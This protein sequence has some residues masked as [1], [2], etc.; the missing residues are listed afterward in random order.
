MDVRNKRREGVVVLREE[1]RRMEGTAVGVERYVRVFWGRGV[2]KWWGLQQHP[3]N[4]STRHLSP[5]L[6]GCASYD[7]RS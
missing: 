3:R 6:I 2:M 5:V 4:G 1:R 7:L